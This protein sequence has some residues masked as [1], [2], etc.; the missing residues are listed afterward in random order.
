MFGIRNGAIKNMI[1]KLM[2]VIGII[3]FITPIVVG[4]YKIMME[5]WSFLDWIILYSYVYWP[6][7]LFGLLLL[8]VSVYKL[9]KKK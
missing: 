2:L 3:P 7:Y 8:I 9:R 6:T 5:S 1:W 4:I